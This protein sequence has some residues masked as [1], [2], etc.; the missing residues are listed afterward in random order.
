MS[1]RQTAS[2]IA[3]GDEQIVRLPERFAL[4]GTHVRLSRL[5]DG[6]LLEPIEDPPDDV[7][8]ISAALDRLRSEPFMEEGR[9]QP[10]MPS[11]AGISF[12]R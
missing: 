10:P 8:K 12:D 4:P 1:E 11:K 9:C 3:D 7:A 6:I 5:G 2:L